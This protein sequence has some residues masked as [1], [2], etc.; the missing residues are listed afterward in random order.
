MIF[1][2]FK[3][4][5][6]SVG[7]VFIALLIA[8]VVFS[9]S[10]LLPN[11]EL[12]LQLIFSTDNNVYNVIS[13]LIGL[14]GSIKTNFTLFSAANIIAISVLFG[15]NAAM[16][17]YLI[18]IQKQQRPFGI[19]TSFSGL[20]SGIFGIGCAACGTLVLAPFLTFIGAGGV[21]SFLPF[22][23]QEFGMLGVGI[24]AFSIFL[25]AKNINNNSYRV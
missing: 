16:L 6:A 21:I 7:Y 23:G 1:N 2:A 3:K 17:I 25:V 15:I 4:S 8:M 22:G 19:T 12:V 14:L 13:V 10:V 24:L 9:L 5:F 20:M 11:R 18:K